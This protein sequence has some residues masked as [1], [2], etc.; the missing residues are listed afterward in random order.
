MAKKDTETTFTVTLDKDKLMSLS[1][2]ERKNAIENAFAA[3]KEIAI[4]FF[5]DP[6]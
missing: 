4:A 2:A 1:V 3:T 5:A 6:S